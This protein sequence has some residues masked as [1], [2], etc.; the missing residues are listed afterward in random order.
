M[1]RHEQF[2]SFWYD[3]GILDETIWKLSRF[4]MPSIPALGNRIVWGDHFN[5]SAM[6]VAPFYWL[7]SNQRIIIVAQVGYVTLSALFLY[8]VL[9]K[10]VNNV[11]LRISLLVSYLWFVGMQNAMYT[12]IHNMVFA[13]LP[14]SV[15][16]WAIVYERWSWYWLA[17]IWFLGWQE[18]SAGIVLGLSI[19][20]WFKNSKF[21]RKAVITAVI[22][23]LYAILVTQFVMPLYLGSNYQYS[24]EIP[25]NLLDLVSSFFYPW[26]KLKT[27]V[28]SLAQFTFLP[29]FFPPLWPAIGEQYLE[30]FVF[31]NAATRWDM[32][33][34]YNA[35]LAPLFLLSSAEFISKLQSKVK[36][37][38]LFTIL[39]VVNLSMLFGLHRFYY[40]GP[41]DLVFRT[42]YWGQVERNTHYKHFLKTLPK[43][44]V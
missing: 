2:D 26:I 12:D 16:L 17:L 29:L 41:F 18:N 21:K 40:H 15:I 7:T 9:T 44:A 6:L 23:I 5:P 3:F 35:I 38:F 27:I 39:A 10:L 43:Q 22:G 32:G 31:N 28:G 19:Y 36:G 14:L 20:V 42:E 25:K 24:P 8:Q 30:R 13:V 1:L 33:F 11:T 4:H 34:H 37:N